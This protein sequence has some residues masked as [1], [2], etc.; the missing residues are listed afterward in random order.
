MS[1][2]GSPIAD[3]A[4]A[5]GIAESGKNFASAAG[6][7]IS[8]ITE[9]ITLE[10][11][12]SLRSAA[13]ALIGALVLAAVLFSSWALVLATVAVI[14]VELGYPWLGVL[15]LINV[16]NLGLALGIWMAIKR[17]MERVGLDATRHALGLDRAGN[18]GESTK[19]DS[20]C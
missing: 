16:V 17:L 11:R 8:G 6:D 19:T 1:T 9:L 2:D 10:F 5:P 18:H 12:Y 7:W 4:A 13:A 3:E 14:L 15:V 20:E